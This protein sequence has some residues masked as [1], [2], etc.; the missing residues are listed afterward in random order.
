MTP[1]ELV[2]ETVWALREDEDSFTIYF[3]G[4]GVWSRFKG[5]FGE[6]WRRDFIRRIRVK[7]KRQPFTI[8]RRSDLFIDAHHWVNTA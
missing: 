3:M 6:A 7:H 2:K 1:A 4:M 8:G 5:S